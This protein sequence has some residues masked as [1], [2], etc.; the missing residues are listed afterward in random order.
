MFAGLRAKFERHP[1]VALHLITHTVHERDRAWFDGCKLTHLH[2]VPGGPYELTRA[3]LL[4]MVMGQCAWW[5]APLP[6][7]LV[8]GLIFWIR[9]ITRRRRA[10]VDPASL[11]RSW[12]RFI[13]VRATLWSIV[14]GTALV[15]TPEERLVPMV[16]L[17]LAANA[18]DIFGQFTQ[19]VT[20]LVSSWIATIGMTVALMLRPE[21]AT[22][23]TV[24]LMVLQMASA[25]A[26]IFNLHYMF[27]TRRLRTR[28]LKTANDMIELLLRQ[29]S[30]HG[31]DCLVETDATGVIVDPSDRLARLCGVDL[32]DLCGRKLVSLFEPSSGRDTLRK[33]A[34]R[35]QAFHDLALSREVDGK[36]RW[37]AV[38]GCPLFDAQGRH[39][40]F[41]GFL[42]DVTDRHEAETKVLFL[43]QHDPLTRLANRTEFHDQLAARLMEQRG[44]IAV[45]FVDLDRFKLI[46]DSM[47]H[48][49]GDQVLE[50]VARRLSARAGLHDVVARLGGD[51]FALML[52]R[53]RSAEAA[54]ALARRIVDD[55]GQPVEAEG[56]TIH[57]GASV[58]VALSPD[59]ADNADEL[60]RAADM[61]LY[62]AKSAGRGMASLY[63]PDMKRVL[64]EQRALELE[65]RAALAN[66]EFELHYQPLHQLSTDSIAGFEALLRWRH[67]ERG[68]I[69]PGSFI[70][71]AEQSG[72]IVQIGEWVLREAMAEAATWEGNLT[73]AVN[74]SAV[75]MRD[76]DLLRQVISALSATGLDPRRLEL[77]ITETV[78]MQDQEACLALLHRLRALGVR[79]ALDDFGTGYSSLNY[80]RSFPFDKIKIDRCF[81]EDLCNGGESGAIVESVLDLAARLNM[82]TIAEGVEDEA[83]LHALRARGCEQVQGYWIS[84]AMPADELPVVRTA[85]A[86]VPVPALRQAT[87]G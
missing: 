81:I 67:P 42:R 70:G 66:G 52:G 3:I 30:E 60:L 54:M 37:L 68:T 65:L 7:L 14:N 79:I 2:A 38:S 19:P 8:V 26:R 29:Y 35:L 63:H 15:L 77:E 9:S 46:N 82:Q 11:L 12:C 71:I 13:V 39:Y 28:E 24:I 87:G 86:A 41:R 74:V 44:P 51:E 78:L 5:F 73:V 27:A 4:L 49:A 20:G 72:L 33:A 25:H 34:H 53:V 21:V 55:L 32:D 62:E 75:Q 18:M 61:A 84:K 10:G 57:I 40:G 83:Q 59:H 31:S 48:A 47:G 23:P 22:T 69:A 58:G 56:R 1:M 17:I 50:A 45:L 6:V 43:A 80:L 76:G 36:T 85:R 64:M 16:I